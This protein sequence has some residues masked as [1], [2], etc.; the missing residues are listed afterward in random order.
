M[1]GNTVNVPTIEDKSFNDQ[2]CLLNE[3]LMRIAD[4]QGGYQQLSWDGWK[5]AIDAGLVGNISPVG[6]QLSDEWYKDANTHYSA[7]WDVVNIYDSGDVAIKQH[8]AMPDGIPF[9]E[10]EAL[11]YANGTE[12][13]GT[14]HF[15]IGT[16]Y[17]TG[18]DTSKAIQITTN[19]D[20]AENDQIVINCGTNNANDPTDGRTWYMYAAGSTTVKDTGTTS[21]GSGGTLLGGTSTSGVGYTNGHVNAPQ[22]IVYGYGRYS[23]SAIRQYITSRAAVG[24]WWVQ[25]NPWD[26]PPAVAA[27]LRGW[28]A[29]MTDELYDLLE[30]T[31][32]VT[33]I[34][35]VEGSA[36][37]TETTYDKIFLPSLQEMYINPQLA[38]VEGEDWE[39]YKD[40]AEEIGLPGKFQQY[41]T[42][43]ELITYNVSNTTSPV[44]VWLRSAYRGSAYDAWVV[45]NS[46]YVSG[47]VAYNALRGCPACIIKK[48]A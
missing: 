19:V 15:T 7:P 26:R 1:P 45:T 48:S 39:Y 10:P 43:P 33:A 38:N 32:V 35:T 28:A 22:R 2:M 5:R 16:S 11:Y 20:M 34:N 41:Q 46:G 27:T 3:T 6:S 4:T 9:D 40:L 24:G 23:Q 31:E 21:N 44:Y 36:D 17:G 14:Y 47:N 42:Y 29:G 12:V 25:K 18:W 30:P 37:T 8:Y 13:A